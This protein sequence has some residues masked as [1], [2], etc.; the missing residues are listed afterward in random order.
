M[1]PPPSPAIARRSD[2]VESWNWTAGSTVK[3]A[4]YTNCAE[5]EITLNG[6]S[7]GVKPQSAAVDGV[8]TWEVPYE[9]G[10][11]KAN[12]DLETQTVQAKHPRKI[13]SLSELTN[14]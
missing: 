7:F 9:P 10:A 6:R 2:A 14:E 5:I 11:L 1:S 3:V 4:C 12:A 13:L 8:L